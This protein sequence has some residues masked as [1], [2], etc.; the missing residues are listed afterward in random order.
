MK[1]L[2]NSSSTPLAFRYV[3]FWDWFSQ[4]AHAF[5]HT[6]K[7][8]HRIKEDFFN[9]LSLALD[10]IKDGFYFQ[11]GMMDDD[12]AELEISVEGAIENITFVEELIQAAPSLPGWKFTAFKTATQSKHISIKM[13]GFEFNTSTLTFYTNDEPEYPDEINLVVVHQDYTEENES[14]I[15]N[16][17]LNF[18]DNYL[19]ELAFATTIDRITV[20]GPQEAEQELIPL[21]KLHDFLIWR[22]KEFVEKYEGLRHQ[23][24]EDTYATFDAELESGNRLVAIMNTDLLAWDA[25][26]SHPWVMVVGIPYDG[27]YSNGMPDDETYA[28]LDELE[29]AIV[30][31]LP[32]GEGYLNLGRQTADSR[33]EIY[34]A[35]QD[36]RKPSQVLYQVQTHYAQILEVTY[37]IYKDKYWQSFRRFNSY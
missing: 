20:I 7:E 34:F 6:V 3:E 31:E 19:G 23:T 10:R 5:F 37:E 15:W 21:E 16:G 29:D 30:S 13:S 24:E 35:C 17:T 2:D 14:T 26:A 11:T 9:P 25:K 32:E 1:L 28:T 8:R 22:Q 27:E 12:T 18:L 33:R 36:F 4:H